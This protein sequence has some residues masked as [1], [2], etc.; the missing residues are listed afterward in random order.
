MW[1]LI[2]DYWVRWVC[3]LVAAIL[4]GAWAWMLRKLKHYKQEQDALRTGVVAML[5]DRLY[6]HCMY[7]IEKGY[8]DTEDRD[9]VEQLY[10]AYHQLGGNGTGTDLYNRFRELPFVKGDTNNGNHLG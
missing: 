8:A 3:G 9:N 7:Y 10:K 5:H 4:A 6:S 1:D 2:R